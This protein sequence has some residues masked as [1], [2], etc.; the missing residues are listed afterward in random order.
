MSEVL[1]VL[2][3]AVCC[4]FR[5]LNTRMNRRT[6]INDGAHWSVEQNIKMVILASASNAGYRTEKTS[7]KNQAISSLRLDSDEF[8][9]WCDQ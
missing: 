3:R 5:L 8:K 9:V 7:W 6:C 1:L 4:S 2:A